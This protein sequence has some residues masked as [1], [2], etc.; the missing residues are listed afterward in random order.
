MQSAIKRS[1][2]YTF[3]IVVLV[4]VFQVLSGMV[5]TYSFKPD[6]GESLY[7]PKDSSLVEFGKV[8]PLYIQVFGI[9]LLFFIIFFIQV[10]R[11]KKRG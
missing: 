4:M 8:Q 9:L 1:L 3:S 6:I 7:L 2:L 10:Y 5:L 11:M